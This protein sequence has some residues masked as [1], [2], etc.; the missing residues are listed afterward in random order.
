MTGCGGRTG[1]LLPA[2]RRPRMALHE[3]P[4]LRLLPSQKRTT[5]ST[6]ACSR[7]RSGWP[8]QHVRVQAA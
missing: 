5:A 3:T 4:A 1:E 7:A 2:R 6:N 8:P